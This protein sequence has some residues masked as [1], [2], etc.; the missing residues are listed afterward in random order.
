M[1]SDLPLRALSVDI[2]ALQAMVRALARAQAGRSQS[3]LCDLLHALAV[4]A[5]RLREPVVANDDERVASGVLDAWIEDLKDEAM[6][7]HR[8]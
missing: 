1:S 6:G 5:D 2:A 8:A 7:L 4:E 3:A